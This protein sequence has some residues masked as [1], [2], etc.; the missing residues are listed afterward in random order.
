MT[1]TKAVATVLVVGAVAIGAVY[2]VSE[3]RKRKAVADE[4]VDHIQAELDGLD[5]VTR[6]AVVAKLSKDEIQA[7]RPS[8]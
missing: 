3:F 7:H 1:K 6:A 8:R 5:P 2:A 4:A